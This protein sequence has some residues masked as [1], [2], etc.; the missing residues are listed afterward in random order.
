MIFF[1]VNCTLNHTQ[2]TTDKSQ[3]ASLDSADDSLSTSIIVALSSALG[4][5][6]VII[7]VLILVVVCLHRRLHKGSTNENEYYLDVVYTQSTNESE[8]DETPNGE[9]ETSSSAYCIITPASDI[10]HQVTNSTSHPCVEEN[11]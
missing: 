7:T 8:S 11:V 3:A 4:V 1:I 10:G 2:I 5:A 9:L 6:I